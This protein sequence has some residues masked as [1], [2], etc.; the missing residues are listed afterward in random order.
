MR[1]GRNISLLVWNV[2]VGFRC[3]LRRHITHVAIWVWEIKLDHLVHIFPSMDNWITDWWIQI[4]T[5]PPRL[6]GPG[7]KTQT[8]FVFSQPQSG[9]S[10]SYVSNCF[11]QA[12]DTLM[13]LPNPVL[14]FTVPALQ[15]PWDIPHALQQLIHV[16]QKNPGLLQWILLLY[17]T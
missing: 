8:V 7:K 5:L 10:F 6:Q 17:S 12:T 4:M 1:S 13:S 2:W 16:K 3:A 11:I 14:A 15:L 9:A